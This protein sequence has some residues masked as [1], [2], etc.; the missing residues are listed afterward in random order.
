MK[1]VAIVGGGVAGLAA[2]YE[3]ARLRS[4]SDERVQVTLYEA[5]MRLDRKSVV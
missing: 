3:L 4:S 2:A 5:S 1:R